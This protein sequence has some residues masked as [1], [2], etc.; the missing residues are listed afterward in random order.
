VS[1]EEISAIVKRR[2][3]TGEYGNAH[4]KVTAPTL[5]EV[6]RQ[7]PTPKPGTYS[8]PRLLGYSLGDLMGIPYFVD[9]GLPPDEWRL[10]E[11]GTGKILFR[12]TVGES[13][14]DE[15]GATRTEPA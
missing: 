7:V 12:G 5:D 8:P 13:A 14:P 11:N 1:Y 10:I 6:R 3:E 15:P 4:F 2:Y 9:D